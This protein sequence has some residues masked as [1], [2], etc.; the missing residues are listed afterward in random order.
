M[1]SAHNGSRVLG[2][3]KSDDGVDMSYEDRMAEYYL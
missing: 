2:N 1:A 3:A